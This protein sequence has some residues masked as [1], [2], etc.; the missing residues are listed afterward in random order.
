MRAFL[1]QISVLFSFQFSEESIFL[2]RIFPTRCRRDNLG[3]SAILPRSDDRNSSERLELDRRH[4]RRFNT[5]RADENHVG[6]AIPRSIAISGFYRNADP[7]G[8][9]LARENY[10]NLTKEGRGDQIA[11]RFENFPFFPRNSFQSKSGKRR[12]RM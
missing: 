6:V 4:F 10:A 7:N 12:N 11:I 3:R 5:D 1:F 2:R 9:H 8:E